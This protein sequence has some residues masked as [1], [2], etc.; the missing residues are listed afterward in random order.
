MFL[1]ERMLGQ[2][3]GLLKSNNAITWSRRPFSD[4]LQHLKARRVDTPLD[5]AEEIDGDAD[6]FRKLLL[7]E[8]RVPGGSP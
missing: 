1:E 3:F 2:S 4:L 8:S 5:Q 7:R 6:Q